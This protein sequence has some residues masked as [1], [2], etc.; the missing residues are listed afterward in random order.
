LD[1]TPFVHQPQVGV[2]PL[3]T[4]ND[5]ARCL[6]WGGGYE[7]ESMWKILSKY[8]RSETTMLDRWSI[9]VSD[10]DPDPIRRAASSDGLEDTSGQK[11]LTI[12]KMLS[13]HGQIP[14]TIINNYFSIGVDAAI[15]CK[16]HLEREKNPNKFNNRMKN[17][18]WYFEYATSEQ[19]SSSCKNL[20]ENIDLICDG[21]PLN[22]AEGP[23]LQ[24]IALLNIPST[25][26]GTNM[27]GDSTVK[28]RQQRKKS[29]RGHCVLD[30]DRTD[31][32]G[33]NQDIGDKLIEVVGLENCLHMGQVRTGLRS[34]GKRLAQCSKIVIRTKKQ[35]P[36]QIDGE[37][38]NQVPCTI[39]ISHKNQVSMLLAP[40]PKSRSLFS[41]LNITRRKSDD[42]LDDHKFCF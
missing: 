42:F 12:P 7:G 37:P 31:L 10:V 6:R 41:F 35:F 24:G 20:H 21:I 8:E 9:T 26:G 25:H 19:F 27:W 2:V 39:E 5:L 34:S 23:T 29:K 40:P 33:A 14:F 17:K 16:F 15:C 1:K 3:G 38:W 4:G 32:S 11:P 28:T 30:K 13:E 22:L 36:M 18:I